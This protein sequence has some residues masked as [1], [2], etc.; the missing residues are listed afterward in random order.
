MIFIAL[1]SSFLPTMEQH[2]AKLLS[3][4][5]NSQADAKIFLDHILFSF[6]S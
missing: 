1:F 4:V 2:T 6:K 5:K 3:S